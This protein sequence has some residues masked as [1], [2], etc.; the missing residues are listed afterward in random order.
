M[1]EDCHDSNNEERA[2]FNAAFDKLAS[3]T[4]DSNFQF[5]YDSSQFDSPVSWHFTSPVDGC[6]T[7]V[8]PLF[9]DLVNDFDVAFLK[10]L[11]I[12]DKDPE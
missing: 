9:T 2:R 12:G 3:P 4:P 7:A 10:A 6:F 5:D 1:S 8:P 11:K